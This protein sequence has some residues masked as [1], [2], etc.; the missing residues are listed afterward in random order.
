MKQV[1][2]KIIRSPHFSMGLGI[3][4]VLCGLL[5]MTET[6]IERFMG[7]HVKSYHGLMI[8]GLGQFMISLVHIL[9]GAEGL[10]V[11]ETAKT[12]EEELKEFEQK[13]K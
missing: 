3:V 9:S 6:F 12:L 1:L 4:L 11:A 7:T 8:F 5:E 10:V 2:V 13:S